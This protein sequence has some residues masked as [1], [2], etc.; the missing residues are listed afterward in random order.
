MN[1]ANLVIMEILAKGG[2][3][4]DNALLVESSRPL[5][6]AVWAAILAIRIITVTSSIPANILIHL[7]ESRIAS[8]F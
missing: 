3:A 1:V 2:R 5:P 4:I 7:V 6:A 8:G